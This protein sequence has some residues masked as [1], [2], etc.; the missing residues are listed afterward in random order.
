M[1][2]K[3]LVPFLL[4]YFLVYPLF[5]SQ[6]YNEAKNKLTLVMDHS[7]SLNTSDTCSAL[8]E[9]S[10]KYEK[11]LFEK[12]CTTDSALDFSLCQQNSDSLTGVETR[13]LQKIISE[14]QSISDKACK[15]N[16]STFLS[17]KIAEISL[18]FN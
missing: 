10:K 17:K 7:K 1:T 14:I 8:Q 13:N 18:N 2:Y 16:T 3:I 11:V 4:Q 9:I 15:N 6:S 12:S 5:A